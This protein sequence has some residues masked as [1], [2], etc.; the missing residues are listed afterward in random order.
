MSEIISF[1]A[2]VRDK[3][4]KGAARASRREGFIPGIVYGEGHAPQS[5]NIEPKL[6]VRELHRPGFFARLFDVDLGGKK[7]RVLARDVQL[8]PV[9]DRPLHVDFMRVG[10]DSKIHVNVPVH[11][12]NQEKSPGLRRG[13]VLNIVRHEIELIC[14]VNAIPREILVDLTGF[15]INSAVHI[16]MIKLPEGTRPVIAD[17][18]FTISTI[19][20][21][22]V[23]Q[24]EDTAAAPAAGTAAPAAS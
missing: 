10:A 23:E 12:V 9:T 8:H 15:E 21:P 5:I 3:S 22:T 18:D 19:V 24:A 17:R 20:P 6:L 7:Q 13:G 1:T 14:S 4:G 2:S 11:F 16:S